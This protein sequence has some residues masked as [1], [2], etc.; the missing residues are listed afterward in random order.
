MSFGKDN[1]STIAVEVALILY[2]IQKLSLMHSIQKGCAQ[3]HKAP[4]LL[5]PKL[6][7]ILIILF[8]KNLIHLNVVS[9]LGIMW[10]LL[11]QK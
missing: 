10:V 1:R 8:E 7:R 6:N 5:V 9:Y 2:V 3:M 4:I 11:I